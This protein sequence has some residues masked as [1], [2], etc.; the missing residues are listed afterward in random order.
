MTPLSSL[1]DAKEKPSA[2]DA[3]LSE[4]RSFS[5]WTIYGDAQRS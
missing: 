4:W 1:T 5:R 3:D 2:G